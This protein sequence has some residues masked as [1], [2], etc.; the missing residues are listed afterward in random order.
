[1]T[2]SRPSRVIFVIEVTWPKL[3]LASATWALLDFGF[4]IWRIAR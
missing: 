3:I 2:R 1:M 4:A